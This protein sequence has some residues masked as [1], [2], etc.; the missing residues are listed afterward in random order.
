MSEPWIW[1]GHPVLALILGVLLAP[2]LAQGGATTRY[3]LLAGGEVW[4]HPEA[5]GHG[6]LMVAA[7]RSGL[8]RGGRLGLEY[9]TDTARLWVTGF[10]FRDGRLELGGTLQAQAG[11]AGLLPDYY[12]RGR[13]AGESNF[14]SER[15]FVRQLGH[16]AR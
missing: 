4:L 2:G 13:L 9:N 11:Y 8:A 16:P 1:R 15:Q 6:L 12:R 3:S 10:R 14:V 7:A 5:G